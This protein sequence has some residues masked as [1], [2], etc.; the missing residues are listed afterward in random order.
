MANRESGN[1]AAP[2]SASATPFE[3]GQRVSLTAD[4]GVTGDAEAFWILVEYDDNGS[5]PTTGDLH[6][7]EVDTKPA[8][9]FISAALR[10]KGQ[11]TVTVRNIV[12]RAFDAVPIGDVSKVIDVGDIE[13]LDISLAAYATGPDKDASALLTFSFRDENGAPVQPRGTSSI[14]PKLGAYTY[15][16]LGNPNEPAETKVTV[17]VPPASRYLHVSGVP[18]KHGR[19]VFAAS[20]VKVHSA[21]NNQDTIRTVEAE[22]ED[23]VKSIPLNDE[24]IVLY[25]TA[26]PLGHQTLS[27]RPNRLAK[28]YEKLGKWIVFVP[29]SKVPRGTEVVSPTTRQVSREHLSSFLEY[30]SARIGKNNIFV[31]SSFPDIQA[32]VA[33]DYL[34]LRDWRVV[35]EVR[36]DMEEF[37]RVGYSKWF[38]P[39]LE[40]RMAVQADN[41]IT[42]SPRLAAK[43]NILSGRSDSIVIPNG[44]SPELVARAAHLRTKEEYTARDASSIIGYIGHLTPSWFDWSLVNST[45]EKHPEWTFEIIGHGIPDG[46]YLPENVMFL[47]P[48]SHEE[49]VEISSR[50]KVG[51]IPFKAS[52]LT[53]AVDPNKIYEYLAVGLRVVTA[54]MGSVASCPATHIYDH[55]SEF[56]L[57]LQEAMDREMTELE[58]EEIDRFL[59]DV[60]WSERAKTMLSIF[61][62]VNV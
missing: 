55:R 45:A 54:A 13:S 11:G 23:F 37:N 33:A 9:K 36:D 61:G 26:P 53:Y 58:Q 5:S 62:S 52:T 20:Q 31:C 18:W 42:V 22:I 39:L 44:V 59:S 34:H 27:L 49:F 14:H 6:G 21:L 17:D 10:V 1:F 25:T 15:L 40:Q 19:Q 35:Y 7:A 2:P 47:G 8:T 12:L 41:V 38:N 51:L 56:E 30:A 3:P 16:A 28:E 29:F 24:L 50:W 60:L 57:Q 48:R 46:L 32:I 43:M 4:V